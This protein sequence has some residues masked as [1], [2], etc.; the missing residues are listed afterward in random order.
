M[1][2]HQDELRD[3]LVAGKIAP[4]DPRY[5]LAEI[6][7]YNQQFYTPL[8]DEEGKYHLVDYRREPLEKEA[9]A[10]ANR[11]REALRAKWLAGSGDD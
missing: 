6:M 11:L 2:V 1:H 8:R 5:P 9:E 4:S 10:F 7:R 3:D